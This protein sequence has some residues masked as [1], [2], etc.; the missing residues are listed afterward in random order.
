MR[1]SISLL[2]A[3]SG[4]RSV[5]QASAAPRPAELLLKRVS[6]VNSSADWSSE[7]ESF[8][9][10]TVSTRL[11]TLGLKFIF[12]SEEQRRPAMAIAKA[13]SGRL[14]SIR[15]G[16]QFMWIIQTGCREHKLIVGNE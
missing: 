16:R 4:A 13:E 9:S 2:K 7:P 1:I 5:P 14:I 15:S 10:A 8:G 11:P 3:P 6:I 12:H